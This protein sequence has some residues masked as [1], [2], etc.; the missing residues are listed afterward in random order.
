M[1]KVVSDTNHEYDNV[2]RDDQEAHLYHLGHDDHKKY[3]LGEDC[4]NNAIHT[5]F[6]TNWSRLWW[7]TKC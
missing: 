6:N 1:F 5:D 7:C 3:S 2:Y 4:G